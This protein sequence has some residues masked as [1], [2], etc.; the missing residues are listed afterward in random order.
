MVHAHNDYV[1]LA[2]ELGAAGVVLLALFLTW[3]GQAAWRA[4][5]RSDVAPFAFAGA[6]ASATI[7]LHSFVEFPLRTAAM[8][9]CFAM[10]L[11]L[12]ADRRQPPRKEVGDLRPTRHVVIR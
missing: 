9:A 5:K 6:I 11:G 1:E 2:L 7:L 3:W 4:W 10:C 12:L 8:S